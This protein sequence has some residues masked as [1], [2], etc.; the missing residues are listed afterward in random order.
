MLLQSLARK[1]YSNNSHMVLFSRSQLASITLTSTLTNI[2]VQKGRHYQ[3][4]AGIEK[5]LV[6]YHFGN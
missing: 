6:E 2:F 5:K 4:L 3:C 1:Y